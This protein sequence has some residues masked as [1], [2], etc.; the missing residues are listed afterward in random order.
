MTC[1]AFC[2]INWSLD[3]T[4]QRADG[5]HLMDMLMQ[6]V[7]LYDTLEL[8]PSSVLCLT[9]SGEPLIPPDAHHLVLRAARRLQEE[10]GCTQG[11]SIHLHKRIPAQAGLGGGSADAAAA[12]LALNA[13]WQLH[14]SQADLCAMALPLGAD[15]PFCLTGGLC[16]VQGI[17]EKILPLP[18]SPAVP[19]LIIKPCEG[20]STREVFSAYHA[21]S[22]GQAFSTDIAQEA[23]LRGD[24]NAF[25]ASSGNVL[26]SPSSTLAPSLHEALDFL[27]QAGALLARMS[28]S[29]SACFGVFSSEERARQAYATACM[30][31]PFAA[32]CHTQAESV[33]LLT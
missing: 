12:F 31:F 26:E 20:L 24:W 27:H 5:Y 1:H 22:Q 33:R 19:L 3:I 21:Q 11:A 29:G 10:T 16:R 15:I 8:T 13:L 25:A 17:G 18:V 6:P 7:S 14:L 30:R 4:G 32:V 2:K 23:L 28:G 9:V